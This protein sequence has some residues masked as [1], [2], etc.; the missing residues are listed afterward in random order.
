MKKTYNFEYTSTKALAIL[1]LT[2]LFFTIVITV[3]LAINHGKDSAASIL[4]VL[5]MF[6]LGVFLLRR[7]VARK[8]SATLHTDSVHLKLDGKFHDIS[9]SSIKGYILENTQS[10]NLRIRTDVETISIPVNIKFTDHKNAL[11]FFED[12]N[13]TLKAYLKNSSISIQR[14]KHFFISR[15]ATLILIAFTIVIVSSVIN[16]IGNGEISG[17]KASVF[18]SIVLFIWGLHYKEKKKYNIETPS[19]LYDYDEPYAKSFRKPVF[20]TVL[21]IAFFGFT[22]RTALVVIKHSGERAYLERNYANYI[23]SFDVTLVDFSNSLFNPYEDMNP[24]GTF[25]YQETYLQHAIKNDNSNAISVMLKTHPINLELPMDDYMTPLMFA[26][27]NE[28][29]KV[30]K[31][32]IDQGSKLDYIITNSEDF[33]DTLYTFSDAFWDKKEPFKWLIANNDIP[34]QNK[35][36]LKTSLIDLNNENR[37]IFILKIKEQL[38]LLPKKSSEE[39][40]LFKLV[41]EYFKSD[42][43]NNLIQKYIAYEIDHQND[44]EQMKIRKKRLSLPNYL[45]QDKDEK[46]LLDSYSRGNKKAALDLGWFYRDRQKYDKAIEWFKKASTSAK[47]GI[48]EYSL[49]Y[50]YDNMLNDDK[51]AIKYYQISIQKGNMSAVEMLLK[52][53][54][55]VNNELNNDIG[56]YLYPKLKHLEK[57]ALTKTTDAITLAVHYSSHNIGEYKRALHWFNIAIKNGNEEEVK[58]A[59][60]NMGFSYFREG[61]YIQSIETFKEIQDYKNVKQNIGNIYYY[62]QDYHKAILWYKKAFDIGIYIAAHNIGSLYKQ[63]LND[64]PNAVKWYKKAI[65]KGVIDSY[66]NIALIYHDIKKED[67]TACAYCLATIDKDHTKKEVLD[68]LRDD[69]KID[70]TTLQKA[71]KLQKTLVP[72]PYTGGIN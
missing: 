13:N 23:N 55:K 70:E 14:D 54:P 65:Q 20:M 59:K 43:Q 19:S 47:G 53:H 33:N 16:F 21:A 46:I 56:L 5:V 62:N 49:A 34:Y 17:M 52:N 64:I 9:F 48:A 4:S 41:D 72:N 3:F 36:F 61:K 1:V 71:Y 39:K 22:L 28:R 12:F 2:G 35:V 42:E 26:L 40:K 67:L 68:F 8:G 57:T 37:D 58:E 15:D 38:Q 11:V 10:V 6:P 63:K 7:V 27:F 51:G 45:A 31:L 50:M 30:S 44:Y 66:D 60:F 18:F 29:F 69:W 25:D 32:L 24:K